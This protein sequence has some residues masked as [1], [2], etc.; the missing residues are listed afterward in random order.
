MKE[1]KQPLDRLQ[2]VSRILVSQPK[3][4]DEKSPY[5]ALE[6]EYNIQIEF[7]QFIKIEPLPYK[8]F[9]K[10][11]VDILAHTAVIFTSRNAVDN[12]FKIC[13]DGKI[14][15]PADYKYFCVNEQTANYLQKYIT[16]RKRKV[17]IG[18][19]TTVELIEIIKKHKE[20][21]FLYPCSNIRKDD[22]PLFLSANEFNFT[23]IVIYETVSANLEEINPHNFDIIAFFSPSGVTS[24]KSNFPNF[25]QGDLRFAAFGPTTAKSV[26]ENGFILD[27]EAPMPNAPSMTGALE[28]FIIKANKV[29]K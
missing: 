1:V 24:L 28:Q 16:V 10:Q 25:V 14:E 19:K 27:I 6:K 22:I 29:K 5:F 2:K 12:F 9:R 15:L 8:E 3:P 26:L 7:K 23:E 18:N 20:E 4:T 13:A 17:F 21:K 11:K